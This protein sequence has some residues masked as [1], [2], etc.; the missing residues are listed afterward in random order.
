MGTL[1]QAIGHYMAV[2]AHQ[3]VA[4]APVTTTRVVVVGSDEGAWLRLR[5]RGLRR[6]R[7]FAR[8]TAAQAREEERA[9]RRALD[10]RMGGES[11]L[12]ITLFGESPREEMSMTSSGGTTA[13]VRGLSPAQLLEKRRA[14]ARRFSGKKSVRAPRGARR[15]LVLLEEALC[16]LERT[17]TS[18]DRV[19]S[20]T[21][22]WDNFLAA[23]REVGRVARRVLTAEASVAALGGAV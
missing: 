10:D 2:N 9:Y 6:L 21:L 13:P 16:R 22:D 18:L 19:V 17:R 12:S 3:G 5:D 7:R 15:A 4:V 20:A 23:G 14:R 1:R 11:L 8:A